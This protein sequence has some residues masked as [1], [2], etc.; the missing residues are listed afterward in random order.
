MDQLVQCRRCG[1]VWTEHPTNE[2]PAVCKECGAT[3]DE[4]RRVEPWLH[5]VRGALDPRIGRPR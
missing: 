5:L 3:P 4:H 2:P 1:N